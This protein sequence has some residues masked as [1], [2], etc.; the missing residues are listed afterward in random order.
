MKDNKITNLI[1]PS[2]KSPKESNKR[3]MSVYEK[4]TRSPKI[5]DY[6]VKRKKLNYVFF[7]NNI[8]HTTTTC[9]A[10]FSIVQ[11]IDG[12]VLVD[13]LQ[14]TCPFKVIGSHRCSNVYT[15]SLDFSKVQHLK[16]YQLLSKTTPCVNQRP[17]IDNLLVMVICS[18]KY[19]IQII[20]FTKFTFSL[21]LITSYIHAKKKIKQQHY[22]HH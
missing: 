5:S 7:F 14:Y 10:K 15:D 17:D 11:I 2:K 4:I 6:K 9:P 12:D 16:Y 3:K 20:G 13:V 19:G 21:P 18:E 1:E 8:H 22:F